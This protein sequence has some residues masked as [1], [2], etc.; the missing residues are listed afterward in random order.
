MNFLYPNIIYVFIGGGLGACSRYLISSLSLILF[1]A[2]FPYGTL[3]CNILGSFLIGFLVCII[4]KSIF[5]KEAF[6]LLLITGFLGGFTT[7]SSFSLENYNLIVNNEFFKA[8]IYIFVSLIVAISCT[9]IG[10]KFGEKL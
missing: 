6:H 4:T 10:F 1:P 2:N 7:F 8:F 9:Y 5:Y 3:I